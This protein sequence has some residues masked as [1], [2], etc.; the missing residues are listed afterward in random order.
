[1]LFMLF[2]LL[3]VTV[4]CRGEGISTDKTIY[5]SASSTVADIT[6][7]SDGDG[8]S[9]A[10]PIDA[11]IPINSDGDLRLKHYYNQTLTASMPDCF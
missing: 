9:E 8:T 4:P 2:M 11:Y 7:L 1:M 3:L 5:A 10:L 6:V